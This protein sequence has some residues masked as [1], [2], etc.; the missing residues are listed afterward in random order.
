MH[1][2]RTLCRSDAEAAGRF[3]RSWWPTSR[4]RSDEIGDPDPARKRIGR[5][6]MVLVY[7][8][9]GDTGRALVVMTAETREFAIIV[10][11]SVT[12]TGSRANTE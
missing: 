2:L 12:G 3:S 7:G 8:V 11:S 9:S 4:W 5:H 1:G 10:L 6:Q